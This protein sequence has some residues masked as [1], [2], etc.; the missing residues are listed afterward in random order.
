MK[1]VEYIGPKNNFNIEYGTPYL[2]IGFCDGE[3]ELSK[4]TWYDVKYNIDA[5]KGLFDNLIV[6]LDVSND[7]FEKYFRFSCEISQ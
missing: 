4:T 2:V 6:N 3:W 1:I 7:L 5:V